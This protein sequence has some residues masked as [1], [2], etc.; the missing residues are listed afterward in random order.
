M[1]RVEAAS[2]SGG[3]TS[4]SSRDT[5]AP[6]RGC[7]TSAPT[8]KMETGGGAKTTVTSMTDTGPHWLKSGTLPQ[9]VGFFGE[10]NFKQNVHRSL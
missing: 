7:K 10:R 9:H 2:H 4:A 5:C 1:C 6:V 8:C 3:Q